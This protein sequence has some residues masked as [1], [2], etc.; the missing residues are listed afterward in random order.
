MIP[1]K[2]WLE[3]REASASSRRKLQ[4]A[5]GLAPPVADIFSRSTPPPWQVERLEKALKKSKKKSKKTKKSKKIEEAKKKE[6]IVHNDID[7][8]IKSVEL[9]A[10]DVW[11]LDFLKKK[12]AAEEKMDQIAKR[13]TGSQKPEEKP[14]NKDEKTPESPKEGEGEKKDEP[15]PTKPVKP[16]VKPV[17]P[18]P[19]SVKPPKKSA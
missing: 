7:A 6:P 12:K 1:F 19:K 11:K 5:L 3:I 10:K 17:K 2:D 16:V 13:H 9:L 4:A 8:F 14:E 18:K 15:K